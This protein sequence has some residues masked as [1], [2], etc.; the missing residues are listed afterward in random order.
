MTLR[1]TP[2]EQAMLG[3]TRMLGDERPQALHDL[4][5]GLD[6]L[7]LPRVALFDGCNEGFE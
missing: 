4:R 6:E 5:H 2:V 3:I 1:L 7:G